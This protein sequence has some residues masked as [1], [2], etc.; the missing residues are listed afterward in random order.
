[1]IIALSHR[2]IF[3]VSVVLDLY[4]PHRKAILLVFPETLGVNKTSRFISN[5]YILWPNGFMPA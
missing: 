1:M 5:D 2:V 3:T 4:F